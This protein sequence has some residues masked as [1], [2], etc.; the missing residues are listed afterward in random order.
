MTPNANVTPCSAA[1]TFT[2]VY[3]FTNGVQ[4]WV[5]DAYAQANSGV[6]CVTG[7]GTTSVIQHSGNNALCL[8][9][10][11]TSAATVL[12]QVE[13]VWGTTNTVNFGGA[14]VTA[15]VSA[16]TS[17]SVPSTAS[18][19]LSAQI[20]NQNASYNF[21]TGGSFKSVSTTAGTWTT[22][23]NTTSY[24]NTAAIQFGVQVSNI[25]PHAKG[26]IYIADV[27]V[28][29]PVGPT[30][31]PTST[32]TPYYE[33]TFEDNTVDS[34][35]LNYGPS[36][37]VAVTAFGYNSSYGLNMIFGGGAGGNEFQAA[38]SGT[39]PTFPL[40]FSALNI[41][42]ISAYVNPAP[43]CYTGGNGQYNVAVCPFV[44]AGTGPTNYGGDYNGWIGQK[45]QYGPDG[46]GGTWFQ[47]N[48]PTS[49]FVTT[50]S[51]W[52]TDE[53]DVTKVGMDVNMNNSVACT[54]TVD[55]INVY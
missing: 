29:L 26:N 21:D 8:T 32:P 37:S 30:S 40:D 10:N 36:N 35:Y 5:V 16:D 39:P 28:A 12:A 9:I 13:V 48:I 7:I 25:A 52:A 33:W 51:N 38:Q 47:V 3:N 14:A 53:T 41:T 23:T 19:N 22:V 4:C 24:T 50:G 34:W 17:L 44:T 11:N 15:Y 49:N 6:S 45:A 43:S 55:D 46:V 54:V 18:G 42:G 2:P 20:F 27:N 31:T 1:P